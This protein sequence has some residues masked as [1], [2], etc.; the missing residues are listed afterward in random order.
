MTVYMR[1][2]EITRKPVVTLSGEDLGQVKD[3]VFD[4]ST[5]GI[6][7]FTL[8]GRGILSGPLHRALLWENVHALGPDAVMVRDE[9][10]LE[11]DE[12][13]AGPGEE[14]S[15]GVDVL[16]VTITTR[17]GAQLGTVTD[18]VVSTGRTPA[19][20]G[21]EVETAERRRV[22]MPVDGPVT[23]SGERVLVPD[24]TAAH[25]A[26]DLEGFGAAVESLRA[27]HRQDSQEG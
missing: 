24:A 12:S 22:L 17:G 21:Y 2:G 9:D 20:A 15:T 14:E 19:V 4:A 5:G 16:G 8:A 3:L 23:V 6:R 27:R 25:S 18:A 10:A 26:G 1:A 7:C 13:A 11:E